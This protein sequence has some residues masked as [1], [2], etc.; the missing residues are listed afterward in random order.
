MGYRLATAQAVICKLKPKQGKVGRP[1]EGL[2]FLGVEFSAQRNSAF[3]VWDEDGL[4]SRVVGLGCQMPYVANCQ[5]CSLWIEAI[6]RP[7]RYLLQNK[8][9]MRTMSAFCFWCAGDACNHAMAEEKELWLDDRRRGKV[10][11]I[12]CW[13]VGGCG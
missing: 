2:G 9:H 3:F 1:R 10:E 6:V 11:P 8:T 13:D 12:P 7:H 5:L 4:L